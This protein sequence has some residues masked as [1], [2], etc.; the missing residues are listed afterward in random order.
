YNTVAIPLAAGLFQPAFGLSLTPT[1]AALFMSL[2]SSMV[3]V[4]S[5]CLQWYR[6]PN[7][8]GGFT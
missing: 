2:S 4:S 7:P 8:R 1:L 6:P 3:V 5:L